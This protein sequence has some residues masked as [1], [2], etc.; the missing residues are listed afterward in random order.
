MKSSAVYS[1]VNEVFN[2]RAVVMH[3][4]KGSI[5]SC[6]KVKENTEHYPFKGNIRVSIWMLK[7]KQISICIN[8]GVVSVYEYLENFRHNS[9]ELVYQNQP[10]QIKKKLHNISVGV[11]W[12]VI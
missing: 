11:I 12:Y 10:C 1:W 6:D 9:C 4:F 3:W 8:L 5:E 2:K 7:I